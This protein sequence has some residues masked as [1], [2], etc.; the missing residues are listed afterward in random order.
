[1]RFADRFAIGLLIAFVLSCHAAAIEPRPVAE[2]HFGRTVDDPYRFLEDTTDPAVSAFMR[3]QSDRARNALDELPGRRALH[4]RI[5]ALSQTGVTIT[6]VQLAGQGASPRVLFLRQ[7]PGEPSRRLFVRAGFRGAD[8]LLF[9]PKDESTP[10]RRVTIEHFVASPDGR[11]VLVAIAAGGSEQFTLVGLDVASGRSLGL[12]IDR[13]AFPEL[14]RWAP[15][16]KSFFYNR[17]PPVVAGAPTNRYLRTKAF[18]HVMDQAVEA[19]RPLLGQDLDHRLHFTD[20]DIPQVQATDNGAGLIGIVQ[21]GDLNERS[22]YSAAMPP[23]G[24]TPRWKRVIEPADAVTAVAVHANWMYVITH[25]HAPN[26]RVLRLSLQAPD[27]RQAVTIVPNGDTVIR[28]IAIARDALYIRELYAGVDRLQRLNFSDSVYSGGKLEFVRLPFDLA[29]RQMIASPARPG[30]LLRLEGWTEPPRYAQVEERSGNL[31]ETHLLPK[32]AVDFDDIDEV[33]LMAVA[34]DGVK[35]PV[36]LVYRKGTRLDTLRPTLLRAYGAYGITA[37]PSFNAATLAWLERGGVLATCHVRGGGEFGEAWHKAGQKLNKPN[38][39]RDLIACAEMLIARQF[40]RPERLAIQ[41]GSA[42]GIAVGRAMTERPDLFAAV[43]SVVGLLDTLRAEFTPNGP[44]N[45]PE[46]GSVK[47][48]EGFRGLL[49]M[50]SYHHVRNGESYPAVLLMHGVNDPRVEV[51]HSTK[52]AAR[53]LDA[54]QGAA[55]PR[56]VLLR[57]DYDAGHGVGTSRAQRNDE[58]A[59]IYSFI[60]WQFDDPEF[61]PAS[62]AR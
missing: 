37:A 14:S 16:S 25:R 54:A 11:Y 35:V 2:Q 29:I 34:K 30:I 6:N 9:D 33:R 17:L 20:I 21:H 55:R 28:E 43:V 15:D 39:W 32:P 61:Q 48:E 24:S 52:M 5:T 57:L 50:S 56:P 1:M 19:D 26:N 4:A 27:M 12:R 45:I 44:P 23:P 22:V 10:A 8:R 59:D 53:L 62:R 36:S 40:T 58:L 38:T 42:G 49:A 41:G 47:T 51:W 3:T 31:L 18:H 60:L 13:V 7:A 46:F